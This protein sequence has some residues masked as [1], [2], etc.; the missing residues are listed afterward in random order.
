[1]KSAGIILVRKNEQKW[2]YLLLRCFKY[3]DF[4]KGEIDHNESPLQ[5][6]L[7]ELKEETSIH[8]VSLSWGNEFYET[9]IYGKG[10]TACYYLAEVSGH[11]E[12]KLLANPE[13]GIVE[14][15]EYRWLTFDEASKLLVPRVLKALKWAHH[16][17]S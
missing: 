1:M 9:E 12:V 11:A 15:H 4:P 2:E 14:H 13:N 8:Q 6:A 5:A 16:L 10:K 3:W 17:I 7:R